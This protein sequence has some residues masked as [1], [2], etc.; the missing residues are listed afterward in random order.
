MMHTWQ[1]LGNQFPTQTNSFT[2]Y[3][4]FYDMLLIIRI[5]GWLQLYT[6][7]LYTNFRDIICN[8]YQFRNIGINVAMSLYTVHGYWYKYWFVSS[9]VYC[10]GTFTLNLHIKYLE[11][12]SIFNRKLSYEFKKH[13]ENWF[14]GDFSRE[15]PTVRDDN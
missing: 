4:F 12:N 15:R 6:R 10:Y 9:Y 1:D 5:H 2:F 13:Q 14:A 3:F 8:K 11:P 7:S